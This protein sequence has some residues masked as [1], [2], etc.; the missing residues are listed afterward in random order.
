V[1]ARDSPTGPK[2]TSTPIETTGARVWRSPRPWC[3][4]ASTCPRARASWSWWVPRP[5]MCRRNQEAPEL[6]SRELQERIQVATVGP[7]KSAQIGTP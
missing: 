6:R 4:A 2:R 1:S 3:G 5:T 7:P